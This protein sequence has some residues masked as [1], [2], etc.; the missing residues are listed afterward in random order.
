MGW[1]RVGWGG[2]VARFVCFIHPVCG[3]A[4]PWGYTSRHYTQ[5][6]QSCLQHY[7][8]RPPVPSA[9]GGGVCGTFHLE[10]T[11]VAVHPSSVKPEACSVLGGPPVTTTDCVQGCTSDQCP[12][13]ADE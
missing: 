2:V 7:N 11:E 13:N 5:T 1:G 12:V 6:G 3:H 8:V 4:G 10:T 9:G